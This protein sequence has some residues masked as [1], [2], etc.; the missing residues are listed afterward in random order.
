MQ[1]L[2]PNITIT[3]HAIHTLRAHSFSLGPKI[4]SYEDFF[5]LATQER[6]GN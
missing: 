4:A 3:S 2:Q 5:F 1:S 6:G